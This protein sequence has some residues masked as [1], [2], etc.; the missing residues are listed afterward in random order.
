MTS[1]HEVEFEPVSGHKHL[2]ASKLITSPKGNKF[3]VVKSG[4]AMLLVNE[5]DPGGTIV[6]TGPNTSVALLGGLG[7]LIGDALNGLLK[8]LTCKPMQTTTVDTHKD[9]TVTVTITTQCAP[10]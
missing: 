5:N 8:I 6:V 3:R 1:P 10:S 9:G 2:E 4:N 7:D